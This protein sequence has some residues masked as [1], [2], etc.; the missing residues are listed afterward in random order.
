MKESECGIFTHCI[1]ELSSWNS[2]CLHSSFPLLTQPDCWETQSL[3]SKWQRGWAWLEGGFWK[4]HII[5]VTSENCRAPHNLLSDSGAQHFPI[6]A[7]TGT[8]HCLHSNNNRLL[9]AFTTQSCGLCPTDT[10]KPL[11]V[12]S[13]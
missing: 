8:S 7:V 13:S 12:H 9:M 3:T 2:V 5:S 11:S 4:L 1:S 6:W 10:I